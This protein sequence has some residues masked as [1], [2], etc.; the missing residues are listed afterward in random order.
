M[1][2]WDNLIDEAK[3]WCVG[4]QWWWRLLFVI[5][6]SSLFLG[7]LK[8]PDN[9]NLF[10]M[11]NLCIHEGGHLIFAWSGQFWHVAGGTIVQLAAPIYG[12]WNFYKQKDFFSIALCFG[13]LSTNLFNVSHY[14]ADA[15]TMK[16]ELVSVGYYGGDI[17]HDWNYLFGHLG[18]LPYD[19][20]VAGF[21]WLLGVS[22]M[23]FCLLAS[24]WMLWQ[25]MKKVPGT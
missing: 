7:L 6:F 11:L 24:T 16:L 2:L 17:I 18:L 21:V 1:S 9:A 15:R 25:M 4:K 19:Q 3:A 14:M 22:S 8:N 13:W 12:M 23:L 20:V 5:W 10:G